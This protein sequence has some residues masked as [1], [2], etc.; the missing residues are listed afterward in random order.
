R[1]TYSPKGVLQTVRTHEQRVT[2]LTY[3]D[4]NTPASVAS[5]PGLL[6]EVT[7]HAEDSVA[8]YDLVLRF[9]Y[10]AKSRITQVTA[11]GGAVTRYGYDQHDNLAS[12]TWPDGYVRRFAYENTAF[13][14]LL[15]GVIDET[16]SR[17]ATWT[18][19][20]KGRAT[21]VSHPD[22][23]RNVQFAYGDGKT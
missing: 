20:A 9:A 6:I 17:I 7:S 22:T 14:T 11:P 1:E 15:T 8:Y 2:K 16:G 4:A 13:W 12:V 18:Y 3:S 21:A 5:E 19:D 23:T 10:D